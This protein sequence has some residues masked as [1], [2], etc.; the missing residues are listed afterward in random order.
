MQPLSC[1]VA[2]HLLHCCKEGEEE[3]VA[4]SKEQHGNQQ[5]SFAAKL[6]S[7]EFN[8]FDPRCT[9]SLISER[10]I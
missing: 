1:L 6:L 9:L 8:G 7:F 3:T 4:C 10:L 5:E 2:G